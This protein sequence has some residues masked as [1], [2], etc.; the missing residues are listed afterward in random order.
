M[1]VVAALELDGQVAAGE[2]PG[3]AQRAHGGFRA[4][5]DQTD[6][7]DGGNHLPHGFGEFDL[8]LGGRAEA[9]ATRDGEVQGVENDGMP[10]AQ[11]ERSPGADVIDVLVAVGIEDVGAFAALDEGR[12]AADAAIGAH[13]GVDAARYGEQGAFEKLLGS[14]MFHLVEISGSL[15]RYGKHHY[16]EVSLMITIRGAAVAASLCAMLCGS[17]SFI[18]CRSAASPDVA[19]TVNG[20]PIYY[21]E[22]DKAYKTQFPTRA[23]GENEDQVQYRRLE[24]LRQLIDSETHAATRREGWCWW[25]PTRMSTRAS[26]K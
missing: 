15:H 20:R 1:A 17:L 3:Y 12:S 14:G 24:I 7:L 11:N 23:E 8:L 16:N 6:H 22:V 2:S 18:A 10:V 9:G 25:R 5:V 26:T 19:A 13:R 4:G 21:A